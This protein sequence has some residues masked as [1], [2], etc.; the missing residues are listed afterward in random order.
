VLAVPQTARHILAWSQWRRRHQTIAQYDHDKRREALVGTIAAYSSCSHCSTR[1]YLGHF[2][3]VEGLVHKAKAT[4]HPRFDGV[5]GRHNPHFGILLSS[6]VSDFPTAEFVK[7]T[8]D[9][10]KM[11]LA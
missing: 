9:K 1:A 10:T 8:C 6:P 4:K 5:A 2:L 11:I 3:H 7:H